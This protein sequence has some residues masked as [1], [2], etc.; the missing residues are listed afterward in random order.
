MTTATA[1]DLQKM[2]WKDLSAM[3]K[4]KGLRTASAI[5]GRI[6][7][8]SLIVQL[9]QYDA[10]LP[11]ATSLDDDNSE[12]APS[13]TSRRPASRH[14]AVKMTVSSMDINTSNGAT[15]A[16][17]SGRIRDGKGGWKE[18]NMEKH[19]EIVRKAFSECDCDVCRP[20]IKPRD[21]R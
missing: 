11:D 8:N 1:P 5:G 9:E 10:D 12:P 20:Y 16:R 13:P 7:K 2:S 6:S 14:I 19:A 21:Q 15:V 3:C 18:I 4:E 17:V